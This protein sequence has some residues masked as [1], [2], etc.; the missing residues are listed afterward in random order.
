[1]KFFA[2]DPGLSGTGWAEFRTPDMPS[3][4]GVIYPNSQS[5]DL[6]EEKAEQMGNRLREAMFLI[7]GHGRS[8]RRESK[9]HV[10]IEMPQQMVSA[11][12]LAAQAGSVYKL[13]FLVGYLARAVY[14]CRVHAITVNQW[15]GQLPKEVVISRVMRDVGAERCRQL[16]IRTHAWDAVGLGLWAGGVRYGH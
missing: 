10:Y 2:I 6:W 12:G 5:S 16:N 14:P 13:A 7:P 15:K 9:T 1:M 8:V 3:R 11:R 4:V